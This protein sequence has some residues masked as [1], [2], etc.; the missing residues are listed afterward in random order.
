MADGEREREL[1]VATQTGADDEVQFEIKEDKMEFLQEIEKREKTRTSLSARI[2]KIIVKTS[3][4]ASDLDLKF[5]QNALQQFKDDM[6]NMTKAQL[7]GTRESNR[8]YFP[9]GCASDERLALFIC[10]SCIL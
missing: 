2:E 8:I 4:K 9:N 6:E 1:E 5:K 7:K 3:K 10:V